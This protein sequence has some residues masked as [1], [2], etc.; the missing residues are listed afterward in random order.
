MLEFS[1][2]VLPD[3][4]SISL[5]TNLL[6]AKTQLVRCELFVMSWVVC[7]VRCIPVYWRCGST[8]RHLVN[9]VDYLPSRSLVSHAPVDLTGW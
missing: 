5:Q 8:G 7:R 2:V 4:V 9:A 6:L 3:A 1:S